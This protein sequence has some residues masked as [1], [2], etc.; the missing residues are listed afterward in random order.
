ME[1]SPTHEA[2][3][4][5]LALGIPLKDVCKFFSLKLEDWEKIAEGGLFQKAIQDWQGRIITGAFTSLD[6]NLKKQL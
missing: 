5:Y 2:V 1:T 4:K 3:A 6:L